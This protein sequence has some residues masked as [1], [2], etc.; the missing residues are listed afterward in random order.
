MTT[1]NINIGNYTSIAEILRILEAEKVSPEDVAI[2]VDTYIEHGSLGGE[3][4][5]S[6]VFLEIS[7]K[8]G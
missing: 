2:N 8:K 5:T 7:V 6:E 3:F 1:R 4:A